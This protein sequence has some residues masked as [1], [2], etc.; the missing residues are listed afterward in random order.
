MDFKILIFK[1]NINQY[2]CD[3]ISLSQETRERT[4]S[5]L[6]TYSGNKYYIYKVYDKLLDEFRYVVYINTDYI[7]YGESVK[8]VLLQLSDY[9]FTIANPYRLKFLAAA[10]S[11]TDYK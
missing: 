5:Y 2:P 10:L 7:I 8:D 3:V 4:D 1:R 6:E 11:E 9:G